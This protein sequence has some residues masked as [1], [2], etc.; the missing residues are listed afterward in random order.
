[1]RRYI[2]SGV[3]ILFSLSSCLT[4]VQ[5]LVTPGN[6]FTDDRIEGQWTDSDSR[7]LLI[8]R[9]M[10]SKAKDLFAEM[11]HYTTEDSVFYTK[12]YA[13]S[14]REKN[15]DYLWFAGMCKIKDQFY[16]NL[17]PYE[18]LDNNGKKAYKLGKEI[19]SI[20]KLEWKNNNSLILHFLDGD[21]IKQ[22]ILNGN[23]RIKH[24]YDPLFG[25]FVITASS[26]ELEQFL[27]KY[28]NSQDLFKGGN[29]II[30]SRKK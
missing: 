24:E 19:S 5:S 29:T 4:I 11:G 16:I 14:Y 12:F 18:C 9:F 13:I 6:I 23:A 20:A 15:L 25:T 22:I 1:M 3:L 2:L 28:G 26:R 17:V 10:K 30:L 8:Q 27:E 21:Y 7:N